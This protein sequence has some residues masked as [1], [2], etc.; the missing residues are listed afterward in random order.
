MLYFAFSLAYDVSEYKQ[1]NQVIHYREGNTSFGDLLVVIILAVLDTAFLWWIFLSLT[2]IL[3]QLTLRRQVVKLQL[4]KRVFAVLSAGAVASVFVVVTQLIVV[5][6]AGG[7]DRTNWRTWWMWSA[8]WSVL[9][10]AILVAI[11]FLFRP[12]SNNTRYGHAEIYDTEDETASSSVALASVSGV[13]GDLTQRTD[14][15]PKGSHYESE[16][17]KNIKETSQSRLL[18]K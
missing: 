4:Y 10:W 12:R 13:Y 18:D 7:N 11:S 2:R 15:S 6:I 1:N 17:E 8:F 3:Q 9:Y 14:S 16:R 5:S